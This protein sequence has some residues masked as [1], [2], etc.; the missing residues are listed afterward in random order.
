MAK[1]R[2]SLTRPSLSV[3]DGDLIRKL[4]QRKLGITASDFARRVGI[5]PQSMINIEKGHRGASLPLLIRIAQELDE[6]L[7]SLLRDGATLPAPQ[8]RA[9][10]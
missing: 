1:R 6:P 3:Q 5:K 2:P 10:A 9:V 7:Q 8:E 4:R